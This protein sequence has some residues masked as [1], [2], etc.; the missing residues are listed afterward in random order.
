MDVEFF[1]NKDDEAANATFESTHANN[2]GILD[3]DAYLFVDFDNII[4][5]VKK[6]TEVKTK[7]WQKKSHFVIVHHAWWKKHNYTVQ[8]AVFDQVY[9]VSKRSTHRLVSTKWKSG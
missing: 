9:A 6:F 1:A 5:D 2:H 8:H 3:D 7:D 4:G